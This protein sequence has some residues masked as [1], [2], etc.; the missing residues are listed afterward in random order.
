MNGRFVPQKELNLLRTNKG[1][2]KVGLCNC[3]KTNT[4]P[5]NRFYCDNCRSWVQAMKS[6]QQSKLQTMKTKVQRYEDIFEGSNPGNVMQML[7][8]FKK[9]KSSSD[10]YRKKCEVILEK[11][12]E[13]AEMVAMGEAPVFKMQSNSIALRAQEEPI[14]QEE[15]FEAP[16]VCKVPNY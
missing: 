7:R 9:Y 8:S 16:L 2:R 14:R 11:Y 12:Q 6:K 10:H 15:L 13:L 4:I 5:K 3:C 1:R